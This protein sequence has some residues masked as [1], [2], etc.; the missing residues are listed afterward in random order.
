LNQVRAA[1]DDVSDG[2]VESF[3]NY[4]A[5][6]RSVVVFGRGRS[7]LVGRAFVMRLLHLGIPSYFVGETVSPPVHEEDLVVLLSGSGETF[8]VVVTG[9]IAKKLGCK[10]VAI[11][12]ERDSE[13]ARLADMAVV[14][15]L[16]DSFRQRELAPLGTCFESS[17][18]I[19]L[20]ALVAELMKRRGESEES[21]RKRHATL[22]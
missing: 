7:G 5:R 19:F 22:E 21:M 16:P 3:L 10:I 18:G 8:S 13:L 11:T 1:V 12:A 20:D 17:A 6:A 15:H 9:Q 2:D 14:M 4:I